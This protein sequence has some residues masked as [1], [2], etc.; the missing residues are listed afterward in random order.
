MA[1]SFRAFGFTLAAGARWCRWRR[2][3]LLA[4]RHGLAGPRCSSTARPARRRRWCSPPPSS[5]LSFGRVA[6]SDM[7]LALWT[8]LAV[9]LSLDLRRRAPA[10]GRWRDGWPSAPSLGLGFLTKGPIALLLP[11]LGLAAWC[12]ARGDAC[13]RSRRAAASPRSPSLP[14]ASPWFALVYR[15]LGAA[16]LE[17][18]FLRENLERFAGETYDV[19]PLVLLLPRRVPRRRPAVVAPLPAGG[20]A[21][22]ARGAHAPAPGS[23][24]CSSR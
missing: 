15:R 13:R 23:P 6:M 8:T 11:G 20:L 2:R 24:S 3:S 17:Y 10:G 22:A 4:R 14:S 5:F 9:A 16:P 18:F 12:V 19:G 7:L 1:A 21:A